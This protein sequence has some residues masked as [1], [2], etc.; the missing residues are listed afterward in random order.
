M[1]ICNDCSCYGVME[2]LELQ[3]YCQQLVADIV[4]KMAGGALDFE[5]I[6]RKLGFSVIQKYI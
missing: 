4:L 2:T 6:Q 3:G 1:G 5:I